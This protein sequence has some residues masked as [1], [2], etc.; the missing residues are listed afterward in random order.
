MTPTVSRRE[1]PVE[2][3]TRADSAPLV[4]LWLVTVYLL[5]IIAGFAFFRSGRA[6]I[7]GN[8]A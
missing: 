4:A 3:P 7:A 2:T 6:T 1:H 5:L 8:R